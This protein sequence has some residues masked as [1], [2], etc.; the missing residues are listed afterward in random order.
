MK[1]QNK[2]LIDL[3]FNGLPR[4]DFIPEISQVKMLN[5]TNSKSICYNYD[6]M[7]KRSEFYGN[8]QAKK[9]DFFNKNKFLDLLK[10]INASLND[11][12]YGFSI[13]TDRMLLNHQDIYL[14]KYLDIQER[15]ML[16][17]KYEKI[18]AYEGRS[19][20][21]CYFMVTGKKASCSHNDFSEMEVI[22]TVYE[23]AYK[24]RVMPLLTIF[25][26]GDRAG[27]PLEE[28]VQENRRR[29]DGYRYNN[30]DLLATSLDYY[31]DYECNW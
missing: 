2:I 10:E 31:C 30:F 9:N 23:A 12:F 22:K 5:L 8:I 7:V 26:W 21:F 13:K 18:M 28:Y 6:T 25:P 3:E 16:H 29:A 24:G 4:Y 1:K 17:K 20:E 19:L 11:A 14:K 15:L 27:Q